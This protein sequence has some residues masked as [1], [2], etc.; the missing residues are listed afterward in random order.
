LRDFVVVFYFLLF[1]IFILARV[2]CLD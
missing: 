2:L 1:L